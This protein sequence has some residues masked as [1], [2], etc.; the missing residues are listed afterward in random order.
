LSRDLGTVRKVLIITS[1]P[2]GAEA[3]ALSVVPD[4]A[5]TLAMDRAALVEFLNTLEHC[6][7][8]YR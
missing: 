8:D 5:A 2:G 7:Q 6:A 1:P 4:A 3:L